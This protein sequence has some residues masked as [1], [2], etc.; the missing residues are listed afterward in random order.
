MKHKKFWFFSIFITIIFILLLTASK[1]NRAIDVEEIKKV[2]AQLQYV[3]EERLKK[4]TAAALQYALVLSQNQALRQA[5][6][7]EDED[8]GYAI[9]SKTMKSI[10][11]HTNIF[12]RTQV[13]NADLTIFAR[14][15]DNYY[16]GMSLDIYRPD[17]NYFKKNKKPR[18][19]IEVGRRLGFK[20]TVP[21]YDKDKLLGFVEVLQF[22][23]PLSDYFKK[24]GIDLFI[25]LDKRYYNLA[26]FMHL[27]PQ[28][29]HYILANSHYNNAYFNELKS[30][31]FTRLEEKESM[32]LKQ[33]QLFLFPMYNGEKERIG[34]FMFAINHSR[35]KILL[36]TDEE[37]SFLLNFS[38]SD[39]FSMIKKEE[40]DS[41]LL[42]SKYDEDLLN[43][44]T[45]STKDDKELFRQEAYD[46][47][48]EY[49]KKELIGLLLN[50]NYKKEITGAIK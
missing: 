46:R 22:F 29:G 21:I 34:S 45:L 40:L 38:R 6:K 16:A 7:D 5:I 1:L 9:L 19:A 13:I 18:S 47:L 30:I 15:W 3:L 49:S 48:N 50:Y 31:D 10:M 37:L 2:K 41:K 26:V 27:N 4:E 28:L 23:E 11:N 17:L 44:Y 8:E 24:M 43:L 33:K 25:L 32:R 42:Q 35:L 39:L 20:A 14:S 12:I 36:D